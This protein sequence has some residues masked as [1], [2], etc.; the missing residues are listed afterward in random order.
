MIEGLVKVEVIDFIWMILEVFK[1]NCIYVLLVV[2][3]NEFVGIVIIYDII[4]V[5]VEEFI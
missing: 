4:C 1:I 5:L 2:E 3:N